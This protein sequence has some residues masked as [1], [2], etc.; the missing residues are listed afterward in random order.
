VSASTAAQGI[1]ELATNAEV[2]TG[3]DTTRAVTPAG[4]SAASIGYGQ[5]WQDV[6]GSRSFGVTYT[7]TTGR[8][9]F[10]IVTGTTPS[11]A[12]GA[13][14]LTV[15]GVVVATNGI[16]G[17]GGNSGQHRLPTSAIVPPGISYSAA[18]SVATSTLDTWV[19][20]R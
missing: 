2:Q 8:P 18:Q 20:L 5:T 11:S 19:E 10:V 3:T 4:F 14:T 15:G 9:I 16:V 7:N 1:V 13:F 12:N 17:N 6:T